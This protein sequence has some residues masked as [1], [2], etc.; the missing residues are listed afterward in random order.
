MKTVGWILI[1]LGIA[2]VLI[3]VFSGHLE[4]FA[5]ETFRA[6]ADKAEPMLATLSSLVG[7]ALAIIGIVMVAAGTKRSRK[8]A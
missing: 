2:I 6:D 7:G 5:E 3:R 1:L 4:S 8:S